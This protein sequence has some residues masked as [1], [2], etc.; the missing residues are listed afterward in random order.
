MKP[1]K[2]LVTI[3]IEGT[4]HEWPKEEIC[5]ADVV[6]LEEPNYNESS[7]V[8]YSITYHRGRG[9]KPEGILPPEA[10][11]KIKEGMVFHVCTTTQS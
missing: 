2:K 4:P 5:Y 3:V 7:N 9:N 10:C 1:E 8:V 11:V 6:R